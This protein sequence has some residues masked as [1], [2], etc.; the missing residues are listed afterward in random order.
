MEICCF[1]K[2]GTLTTDSLV[3][4]GVAGVNSGTASSVVPIEQAPPETVQ[5]LATCHSLVI[6]TDDGLVGDPLE[7]A[8]LEA[9]DWNLTK[10][11]AV[12]PRKGRHPAM[13]IF[14]RHHFSSSLKRMSVIAGYT[15]SMQSDATYIASVKGAPETLKPMFAHVPDDYDRTYLTLSRRGARVLALGLKTIDL[16]NP[17]RAKD[18]PREE[19]ESNLTFAGFIVIS[20]PLKADS[21]A[22][23]KELVGASHHVV[24]ITGN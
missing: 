9:I 23:I 24:M 14:H 6:S 13:K 5:V 12:I 22:V 17:S 7:K 8:T 11:E 4:D 19:L 21:K 15:P 1:D 3:V 10:G 20:C 16:P 2:T 18:L